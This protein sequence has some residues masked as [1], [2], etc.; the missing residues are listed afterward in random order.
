MLKKKNKI[1][2]LVAAVTM[3]FTL[4]STVFAASPLVNSSKEGTGF[5]VEKPSALILRSS[6]SAP[7]ITNGKK[8]SVSG[9]TLWAT[10]YNGVLFR[11]N[12][13]NNKKTHRCS[14]TN[15]HVNATPTRSAWVS[16]GHRAISPWLQQTLSNNKVWAATK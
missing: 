5:K 14:A 16:K 7:S 4:S 15:D 1:I 12:Y 9:G 8:V 10:W 2:S 6:S 3:M 11:A 13:D